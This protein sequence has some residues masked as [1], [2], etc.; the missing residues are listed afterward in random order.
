M[1]VIN[2]DVH[3]LNGEIFLDLHTDT[4]TRISSMEV[5]LCFQSVAVMDLQATFTDTST[6]ISSSVLQSVSDKPLTQILLLVLVI[7]LIL[8]Y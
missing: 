1:F 4:S 3:S 7:N 8:V 2:I 6:R 5:T